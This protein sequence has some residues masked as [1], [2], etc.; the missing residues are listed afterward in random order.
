MG[1]GSYLTLAAVLVASLIVMYPLTMA[2]INVGGDFFFNLSNLYM[3]LLMVFPMGII[4][5]VAMW[6]MFPRKAV[7][8]TLIAALAVAFVATF[9]AGRAE[10]FVGDRQFLAS[11]IPHHSRAIL[12]CEQSDISDPEIETLCR[13]I[14]ASQQS[15]IDQMKQIM[16]RLDR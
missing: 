6:K 1:S 11:M 13:Q 7:N 8:L 9:F 4:M 2:F 15:E 5:I 12:V 3:A 14:I 16:E 10:L